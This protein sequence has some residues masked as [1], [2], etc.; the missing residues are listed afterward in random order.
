[1][2]TDNKPGLTFK[3]SANFKLSCNHITKAGLIGLFAAILVGAGEFLLHF[4]ALGRFGDSYDFMRG[5]EAKRTTIG[6]FLGVIGVPLYIVGFWHF[7]KMLEPANRLAS[8]VA[9][10]LLSYGIIVGGVWIGSRAGISAIVNDPTLTDVKSL[11]SLYEL[12]YE[13]LLQVTRLAV[14]GFSVIFVWL[15]LSGRSYYP[16][17]M[18]LLN[19]ICLILASFVIWMVTPAV[20]IYLMPIAL[21][22]AFALLF[23]FS[24]YYS[25]K[26]KV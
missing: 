7:M 4:D 24:I 10:A 5:I 23:V 2:M 16:R 1:M 11:I 9:F 3:M 15:I 21:N 22:V 18:T 14:L 12:R 25:Q 13:N 6:H 26:I 17:W 20:G 19:P 8:R